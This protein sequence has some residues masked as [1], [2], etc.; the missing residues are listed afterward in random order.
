MYTF[1]VL[2]STLYVFIYPASKNVALV[3]IVWL[4]HSVGFI[5][6][7]RRKERKL[8]VDHFTVIVRFEN[9]ILCSSVPS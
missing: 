5:E 1:T 8:E 7:K 4:F 2:P 6:I 9:Q 3:D